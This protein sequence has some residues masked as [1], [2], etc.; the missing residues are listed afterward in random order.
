[1]ELIPDNSL[2]LILLMTLA[3]ATLIQLLYYWIFFSRLAYYV[4]KPANAE[5]PPVSIVIT[6]SNQYLALRDNLP[7]ILEQDYP[8]YEVVIVNDNSDDDTSELLETF[9]KKY[10]HLSVVELTQRLNWFKGR[11]FPLSLGIKSAKN[12]TLVLTEIR[13]QPVGKNWLPEIVSAYKPSTE[14]VLGYSS[15]RTE[16]GI[17]KW[18][19]FTAFYDAM[20]YLSMALSG[21]AFKAIGRN[22]SYKKALFYRHKGFSSHYIID[23]GDDELFVNKA[24]TSKNVSVLTSSGSKVYLTRPVKFGEWLKAEKTRLFI[25]RFFKL[26]HRLLLQIFNVSNFIFYGLFITCLIMVTPIMPVLMLFLLRLVSQ[27]IIFGTI[28]KRLAEKKIL[29]FSPL[30]EF[31]LILIDFFIWLLIIFSKKKKWA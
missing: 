19:R 11:K 6:V 26:K 27:L 29:L 10:N 31:F 15:Y 4:Q 24:A 1:M 5:K 2:Q 8:E 13:C 22:L 3:V 7:A 23:A 16:S 9:T 20:F 25:R 21:M 14:I 18:L 17:N 12:E 28:Q 30:F